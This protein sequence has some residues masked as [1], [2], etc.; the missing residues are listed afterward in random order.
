M[1][2]RPDVAGKERPEMTEYGLVYNDDGD[3]P[4][5][6]YKLPPALTHLTDQVDVLDGTDVKTLCYCAAYGSDV[7]YYDTNVGSKAGWREPPAGAPPSHVDM[8]RRT[9]GS[10]IEASRSCPSLR[11]VPG[12]RGSI[13]YRRYA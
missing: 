9:N 12:T 4:F 3:R 11:N 13:S 10:P 2:R 8:I 7:M 6:C 5:K 1:F